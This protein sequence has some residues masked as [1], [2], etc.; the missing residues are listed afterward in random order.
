MFKC[1]LW[2]KS[3]LNVLCE[4]LHWRVRSASKWDPSATECSRWPFNAIGCSLL[5]GC[6]FCSKFKLI[7]WVTLD[8]QL[9]NLDETLNFALFWFVWWC[10]EYDLANVWRCSVNDCTVFSTCALLFL[11]YLMNTIYCYLCLNIIPWIS[12]GNVCRHIGAFDCL[13]W[14]TSVKLPILM[15]ALTGRTNCSMATIRLVIKHGVIVDTLPELHGFFRGKLSAK[16]Y[17]PQTVFTAT[18]HRRFVDQSRS[19]LAP[20]LEQF[21]IV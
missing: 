3:S 8:R 18:A 15:V 12:N 11:E 21:G 5:T 10:F 19:P 17:L 1:L 20:A 14:S 16:C 4:T 13:F 7:F 6:R 9:R 2:I